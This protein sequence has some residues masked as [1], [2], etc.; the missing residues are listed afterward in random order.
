MFSCNRSSISATQLG[1]WVAGAPIGDPPRGNASCFVIG[2]DAYV[3]L[4]YNQSVGGTGRLKDFWRFSVDSGWQQVADFPGAP[5][6]EAAAFSVGNYGYVGTGTDLVNVYRDFYQY[7]PVQNVWTRKADFPGTP[8]YDAVGFGIRDKGYIGTGFNVNWMNDFYQYDPAQDKWS[9]TPG[10]SG[11]FSKRQGAVAFVYNDQA[12]VVTGANSGGMVR[13][14]WRF[15]PSRTAAWHQL[16][17]ITNTS[18]E[19]FDDGYTDIEREYATI[20]VNGSTAYLATG[21]N[22]TMVTATWA[23]DIASD[24]WSR[25]TPWARAPRSGAIAFTVKD[26]S[27]VGTGN[28]GNNGTFDDFDLFVPNRVYNPNDY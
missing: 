24:R 20:F 23:Y 1:D 2:T 28:N 22:G 19:T 14:F 10:T 3:G 17:N 11:D 4:G 5:R 16:N 6:S 15:D 21:T 7:D 18:S 13:D 9:L 8:R 27:F 25:R 26:S 12:Y